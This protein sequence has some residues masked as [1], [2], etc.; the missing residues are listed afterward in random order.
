MNNLVRQILLPVGIVIGGFAL[1]G[2]IIATGPKLEQLPPQPNSPLVRT[3]QAQPESVLMSA[4]THG[5]VLPRTESELVPEEVALQRHRSEE[6]RRWRS[7]FMIAALF[8]L[9]A[10]GF[11]VGRSAPRPGGRVRARAWGPGPRGKRSRFAQSA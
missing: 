1:A 11:F 7:R 8:Y 3:W 10:I 2:L 9:I 4:V 5:T 6:R